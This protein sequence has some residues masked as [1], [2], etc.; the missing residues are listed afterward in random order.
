MSKALLTPYLR[1][2]RIN[3]ISQFVSGSILDI[4][5][6][7]CYIINVLKNRIYDYHGF[8]IQ[9]CVPEL[10]IELV[11]RYNVN[12]K[13]HELDIEYDELPQL[14]M[15]FDTIIMMAV[16]E[17]LKYPEN[18]LTQLPKYLNE[19][20]RL[21]I[22]TPTP[23]ADII[24]NLGSKINIFSKDASEKHCRLYNRESMEELIEKN[25]LAIVYYET[26]ELGLNQIYVIECE[27]NE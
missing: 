22:T 17:H 19:G 2:T 24:H 27:S 10:T 25:G 21:I 6:G 13:F 12:F 15:K 20:G 3:A 11:K 18:I 14:N 23:F 9:F 16:I 4:G 7:D 8:D 26:F 1:R 5:C